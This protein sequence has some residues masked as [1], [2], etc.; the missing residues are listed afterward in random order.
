MLRLTVVLN[1][2]NE[3]CQYYGKNQYHTKDYDEASNFSKDVE[4]FMFSFF[5]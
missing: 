1:R 2:S 4:Y 5:R 3:P